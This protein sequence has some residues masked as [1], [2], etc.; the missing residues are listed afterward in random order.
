VIYIAMVVAV[1]GMIWGGI[2]LTLKRSA[3]PV[4]DIGTALVRLTLVVSL[5]MV[6]PQ[7][8]LNAGDQFSNYVLDNSVSNNVAD[9]FV[10]LAGMTGITAPGAVIFFGII[11][12]FAGLIQAV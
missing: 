8:L 9:R 10:A 6:I 2:R 12:I 3:E 1:I 5:G 7:L 11:L 4:W